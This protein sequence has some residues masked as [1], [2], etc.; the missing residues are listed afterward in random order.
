MQIFKNSGL[1]LTTETNTRRA[2]FLDFVLDLD[3]KEHKPYQKPNANIVYVNKKSNHP[4][5]ILKNIPRGVENRLQRLSSNENCFNQEKDTYQRA[6]NTAGFNYDL[7]MHNQR[8]VNQQDMLTVHYNQSGNVSD[9]DESS[10]QQGYLPGVTQDINAINFKRKR[11]RK[12]I[13]FNPPYN[14]FIQNNIGK[15]FLRIQQALITI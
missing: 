2:Q 15:Y 11:N 9:L 6:L 12:V 10:G 13:F 7:K 8:E 5:I 4:P 1:K 3:G 14:N